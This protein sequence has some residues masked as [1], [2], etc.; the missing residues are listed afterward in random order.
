MEIN[1]H[2]RGLANEVAAFNKAKSKSL[3]T[4]DKILKEVDLY[5][6]YGVTPDE[7]VDSYG[8]LINTIRRR[9]TDLWKE[10]KIKK[11]SLSRKNSAGNFCAAWVLGKD[12]GI[13]NV[14]ILT[15][16]RKIIDAYKA[17]YQHGY[18]AGMKES[19]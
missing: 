13:E 4:K 8:G 19:L 9:F 6:A 10:G 11:S 12:E 16:D 7:F 5:G 17:G 3:S 2:T 14:P 15:L 1:S 18:L